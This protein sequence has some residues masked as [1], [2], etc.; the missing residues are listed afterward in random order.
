MIR[1]IQR[2]ASAEGGG[3][4]RAPQTFYGGVVLVALAAFALWAGSDLP[5]GTMR[6][7][8]PGM[9]P[10]SLAVLVGLCGLAMIV[11]GI[12]RKGEGIERFNLRGPFFIAVAILSFAL[13]IRTVGL[14]LA[15]PLTMFIGGLAS[16]EVRWKELGIFAVVMTAACIL[17]FRYLLNQ[18]IPILIVPGGIH[19]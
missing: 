14:A 17:L 1:D 19:I 5:Q 2:S 16:P 10:R 6:T 7:M 8:G 15:G 9:L 3:F 13:S 12:M 18:P 4:I 11:I